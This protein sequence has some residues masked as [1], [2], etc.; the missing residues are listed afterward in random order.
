MIGHAIHNDFRVLGYSHPASLTRD[1]SRF[2]PLNRKAGLDEKQVASLKR[3]TKAIFNR[4][5]QVGRGPPQRCSCTDRACSEVYKG[6]VFDPSG[7]WSSFFTPVS[8]L[9]MIT[10]SQKRI[11][12]LCDIIPLHI[13]FFFLHQ[14]VMNVF[15]S[16]LTWRFHLQQ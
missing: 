7:L 8:V 16:N 15:T 5:I 14:K 6:S 3:L 10:I 9:E 11:S 13:F 1:T 4:E 2:P 12:T